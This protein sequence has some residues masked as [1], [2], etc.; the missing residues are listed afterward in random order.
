MVYVDICNAASAHDNCYFVC[1]IF[2][3]DTLLLYHGK[4]SKRFSV[5]TCTWHFLYAEL[6]G[7]QTEF[8]ELKELVVPTETGLS[9]DAARFKVC[10]YLCVRLGV[11]VWGGGE[12]SVDAERWKLVYNKLY[13]TVPGLTWVD[14]IRQHIWLSSTAKPLLQ[15]DSAGHNQIPTYVDTCT[16]GLLHTGEG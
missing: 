5:N 6:V 7:L 3:L 8:K 9:K 2:S 13:Y 14:S 12:G 15:S 16:L 1:S 11:C 10:L 4:C